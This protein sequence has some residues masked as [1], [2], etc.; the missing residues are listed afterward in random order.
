[1]RV[2]IFD[3][4]RSGV[5]N[6]TKGARKGPA[7]EIQAAG[8]HDT[9][10]LVL[11]TSS[12]ADE[13]AQ[14][15]DALAGS[16]FSHHLISGLRG[17]AD[18]SADRRVTLSEA[19]EYAYA[20]TVAETADTAAGAQHPTFSY[21][22]K[23]N[24]N[25]VLA[26][27]GLGREGL[28]LPAAAPAGIYYLVDAGRGVVAAE[29]WKV[30]QRRSGG[31]AVARPLQGEAPPGRSPAHRRGAG[32]ARAASSPSTRAACAT[33]RSPTIR[34]RAPP[35]RVLAA[36]FSLSVGGTMQAFFD[37][38]TRQRA[39]PA[40][41]PAGGRAAAAPLLPPRLGLGGRP[42][43][44]QQPGH[45]GARHR[46]DAP[47][48]SEF[49]ELNLGTSLFAEWPLLGGRL[50]PFVG[51]RLA[52]LLMSRKFEGEAAVIP[53]QYLSTFSPGVL[54]GLQLRLG[55]GFSAT[56]RARDPLPAIQRRGQPLPRLLGAG[57]GAGLRILNH[58]RKSMQP[59]RK[60]T[61][62][63]TLALAAASGCGN[64]SNADVDFQL[65]VP[66]RDDLAAKL[67][68]A[69]VNAD[70]RRVLPDHPGGGDPAPT[71]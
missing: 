52:Y 43:A 24:G 49:A 27:L 71:S 9:R 1:M 59:H 21:D 42:G 46:S 31:R 2:G 23:G 33:P 45:A 56:A 5:V 35:G 16:Y 3:A 58:A 68:A 67:P 15:S 62:I 17:S 30:D 14:E 69:L 51:G 57:R 47:C 11:L 19:Y 41:R 25:L 55:A 18:R 54:G 63:V 61:L 44:G 22:L 65:A 32:R 64:Y 60:Q 20:R 39:V 7:F 37:A 50:T 38:P 66:A 13:D 36:R 70:S 34:S 28:Y 12:S 4:C 48:P 10:G 6:R 8:A 40:H 26:E 53:D 29:V